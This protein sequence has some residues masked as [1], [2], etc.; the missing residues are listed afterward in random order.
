MKGG[1][2][3]MLTIGEK[4]NQFYKHQIPEPYEYESEH[5]LYL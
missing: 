4:Q 5:P 2:Y 1:V 3:R